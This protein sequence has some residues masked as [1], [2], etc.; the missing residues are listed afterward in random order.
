VGAAL[1]SE[2]GNMQQ[3]L[4]QDMVMLP[5][6]AVPTTAQQENAGA[7]QGESSCS[8]TKIQMPLSSSK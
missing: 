1:A 3:L 6:P 4:K 2:P 8:K 7:A 5:S